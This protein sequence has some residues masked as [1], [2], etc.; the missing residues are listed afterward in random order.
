MV[1]TLLCAGAITKPNCWRTRSTKSCLSASRGECSGIFTS[2]SNVPSSLVSFM[3]GR[4]SSRSS[5]LQKSSTPP[6]RD[7]DIEP[8][9]QIHPESSASSP[10][11]PL[12]TFLIRMLSF[13]FNAGS[14]H[15]AVGVRDFGARHIDST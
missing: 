11:N 6:T 13:F 1:S 3:T 15:C 7:I 5:R 14:F 10:A 12:S 2:K 8:V 9:S 4:S